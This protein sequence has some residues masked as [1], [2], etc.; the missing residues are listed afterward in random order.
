MKFINHSRHTK[1]YGGVDYAAYQRE[2]LH[3]Y[4]VIRLSDS[5]SAF[6]NRMPRRDSKYRGHDYIIWDLRDNRQINN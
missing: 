6:V 2:E 3:K 4:Q 1:N 5:K